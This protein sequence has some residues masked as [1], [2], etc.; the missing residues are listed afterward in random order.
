MCGLNAGGTIENCYNTGTVSGVGEASYVGGVCGLNAGTIENCYNTGAVSGGQYFGGVCGSN[1][2]AGKINNCYNTGTVTGTESY[3]GGVCGYNYSSSTISN[4]YYL[5]TTATG[6]IGTNNGTL[7]KVESKTST[8]FGSGE[9]AYLLNGSKSDG[10]LAWGQT[11]TGDN[12]QDFPVLGGAKVYQTAPCV[13]YTNSENTVKEHTD[14]NGD[15]TC[16]VCKAK[17]VYIVSLTS[18]PDGVNTSIANLDGGGKIKAGESTTVVAPA[19]PGYTFNGWYNGETPLSADLSF[20]YTPTADITLTAKYTA[21]AKMTVTITGGTSYSVSVNGGTA[22]DYS[23]STSPSYEVGT[24][25]TV[26]AKGEN[27]AYWQNEAGSVLSRSAEY[28][29]TVVN[30]A[31]VTAV[32][33]TKIDSKAIVNFISGY[34]QIINRYQIAAADDFTVPAAPTKT[35]CDFA[36]WS[37]NGTVVSLTAENYNA[38]VKAAIQA[39]ITDALATEDT[40][41]DIINVKATYTAKEQKVTVTVNSGS[42]SGEYNVNDVVT[43]TANAPAENM[44]FSHWT[45]GSGTILSYNTSYSF[46][47]AKDITLTAVYVADTV[48]VEAKGTTEIV[49]VIKDTANGK[50]SFVSMST[51]PEGCTIT[52]AGVV[53]TTDSTIG[54][55]DDNFKAE[56]VSIVRGDATSAQA[57]QYTWT[58]KLSDYNKV[59]YVRA[60][61]VYTD[62]NGNSHTI[63]GGIV[64]AS[65]NG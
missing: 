41:D 55:S 34:D 26:T 14:E 2:Y 51:V 61:L 60:Y 62:K 64:S 23:T 58:A 45:D 12:K 42:G 16:D 10:T 38:A 27:F 57:Y 32:Y 50:I 15:E 31:T 36:G 35:G 24:K 9:V 63:Y 39:A 30:N 13:S 48:E 37:I 1:T 17:T 7:E 59:V 19:V 49:D 47:A 3:V 4:C 44:K 20:V 22:S 65:V 40:T 43:V 6:G 54:T 25:L 28:T 18:Q 56:K 29:F 46:Y 52:K 33:D 8:Q 21:N 53:A 11:L 5:N